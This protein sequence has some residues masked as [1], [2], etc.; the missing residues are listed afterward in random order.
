MIYT[1]QQDVSLPYVEVI[2]ENPWQGNMRCIRGQ[3]QVWTGTYWSLTSIGTPAATDLSDEVKMLLGWVR[4][5]QAEEI[6]LQHRMAQN[7]GLKSAYE[8]F[9]IMDA[10]TRQEDYRLGQE[11]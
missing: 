7:P 1:K 5:K 8:Q 2:S 11:A 6:N 9:K 3:V 10:L 4:E